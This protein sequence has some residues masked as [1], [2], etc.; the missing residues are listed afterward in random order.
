MT[1]VMWPAPNAVAATEPGARPA[2]AA[3]TPAADRLAASV[4]ASA[5]D[6][7]GLTDGA[8]PSGAPPA[9][10]T[11][12][13]WRL[14]AREL[15]ELLLKVAAIAGVVVLVFAFVFGLE[16]VGDA[17]MDPAA[18]GGDLVVFYRLGADHRAGDVVVIDKQGVGRQTR[19]VVA[20]AGDTV[21]ATD[22]GLTVN[23]NALDLGLPD[24]A[25]PPPVN[26][27]VFPV[28]LAPG[29]LFVLGDA[30]GAAQDSRS[31]GAVS[32]DDVEGEV[33]VLIRRRGF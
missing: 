32:S 21:D 23:G 8:R 15:G 28:T 10:K 33:V 14:V 4:T 24:A 2:E 27:S 30:L 22:Q 20:V 11:P 25:E 16:R 9:H 31:Y 3:P 26:P 13:A 1:K 29:E 7:I 6:G 18:K 19:R 5:R 17:G 12:G